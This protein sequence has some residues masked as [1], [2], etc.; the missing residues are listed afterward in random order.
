MTTSRTGTSRPFTVFLC[1]SCPAKPEFTVLEELRATIRRCPH[2][3]LVTTACMLGPLACAAQGQVVDSRHAAAFRPAV[4]QSHV[5]VGT[6]GASEQ[7]AAAAVDVSPTAG[8]RKRL[9]GAKVRI[10]ARD[11]CCRKCN[12]CPTRQSAHRHPGH[13]ATTRNPRRAD[14]DGYR[15]GFG[16]CPTSSPVHMAR[17]VN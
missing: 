13:R 15:Y 7:P 4:A 5:Y 17:P 16:G 10:A 1:T 11:A 3:M 8:G 12:C 14:R 6:N 2:G 9:R